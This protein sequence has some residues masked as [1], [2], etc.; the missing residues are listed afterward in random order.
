MLFTHA[1]GAIVV[2]NDNASLVV[3]LLVLLLHCQYVCI[4]LLLVADVVFAMSLRLPVLLSCQKFA[5][6]GL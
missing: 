4:V 6:V 1:C 2:V 3:L 5:A